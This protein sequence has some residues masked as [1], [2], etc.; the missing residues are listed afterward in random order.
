MPELVEH[1][2]AGLGRID[3]H[4]AQGL[5]G[6]VAARIA[7]G[8]VEHAEQQVL[9]AYVAVM[10]GAGLLGGQ[11]EHLLRL[12]GQGDPPGPAERARGRGSELS[13]AT[14]RAGAL[15]MLSIYVDNYLVST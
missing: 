2:L 4:I 1:P 9:G 6:K 12:P 5:D 13:A 8:Q 10:Q 11:R 7:P 14:A 15:S 3:A